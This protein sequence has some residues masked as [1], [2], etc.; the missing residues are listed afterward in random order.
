[1]QHDELRRPLEGSRLAT[2]VKNAIGHKVNER[3]ENLQVK[4]G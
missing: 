2:T 4:R 3:R 1:M